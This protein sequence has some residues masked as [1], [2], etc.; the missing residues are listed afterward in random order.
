MRKIPLLLLA[1][2]T[3]AGL[4][5]CDRRE[6]G[7]PAPAAAPAAAP[8]EETALWRVEVL[9]DGA[10]ASQLDICADRAVRSSFTRPAPEVD[11]KP[12]VRVADPVETAETYSVRC[13]V[14]D[15]LYRVG[16]TTQGDL[17]QDFTVEM[18]VT[19]QDRDGPMF[20]QVRRYRRLG[21]CPADWKIGDSAAPGAS[22]VVNTLS[23]ETRA[24][25]A[26]PAP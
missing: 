11:G 3:A 22:Q 21:A 12:C 15:Q 25:A 9:Q 23:G 6:A 2:L 5:A 7:A 19:R 26:P 17:A 1:G 14:D 10:V 13:R 20:E 18:A 24:V 16:S 8:G 4:S